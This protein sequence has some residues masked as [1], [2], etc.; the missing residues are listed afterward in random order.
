M[1][2]AERNYETHDVELLAIVESLKIWHHYLERAAHTI[3]V[4]T[5]HENL[6]KFIEIT[7]QS[8]RQI[9]WAQEL[10]QYDFK[11]DYR[12][13]SK[14]SADKLSRLLTENN[15]EKELVE[16]NRKIL[17]KLQQSLSENND[18]LLNTTYRV[19]I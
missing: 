17:D 12:A 7:C 15:V 6:K 13:R 1:L 8:S 14:N 18:Y 2:S 4:L 16:Q 5:D 11:I 19:V 3:P 10:P 9:W